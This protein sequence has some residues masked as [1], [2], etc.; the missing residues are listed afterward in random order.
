[1]SLMLAF[2]AGMAADKTV[3]HERRSGV[4]FFLLIGVL[5]LFLGE[6]VLVYSGFTEYLEGLAGLRIFVDFIAAY[7]GAFV[8]AAI[9]HFIKPT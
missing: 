4:F 5:G 3:A 8:F 7:L 9:V 2:V 1:M 6:F